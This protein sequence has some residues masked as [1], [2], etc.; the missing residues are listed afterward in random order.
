MP[1]L[2]TKNFG[3]ISYAAESVIEF[4]C[5]LPGFEQLHSFAAVHFDE[6]A[7]LVFLQSL[8]NAGVSFICLPVLAIDPEY[9]VEI[10]PED[11]QC[12][13]LPV[14]T[15]PRIG[16]DVLCLAVLTVRKNGPTANLLAPVVVNLRNR[17]AVQAVV[18][19][20]GSSHQHVLLPDDAVDPEP[21]CEAALCS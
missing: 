12:I 8:E 19:T 17:K 18:L 15:E 11:L 7:P 9:R 4:P 6:S 21:S 13:G 10:A 20:P 16:E 1:V 2:E 3:R 14:S 5:G